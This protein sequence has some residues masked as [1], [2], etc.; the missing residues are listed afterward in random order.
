MITKVHT[1]V[2]ESTRLQIGDGMLSY[3]INRLK[4]GESV[5][6]NILTEVFRQNFL[7]ALVSVFYKILLKSDQNFTK[8]E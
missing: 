3:A 5:D 2:T 7:A 8:R 1:S 6:N 4:A